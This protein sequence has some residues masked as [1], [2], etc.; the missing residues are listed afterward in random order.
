[1]DTVFR[2]RTI[3]WQRHSPLLSRFLETGRKVRD[4]KI[5][6]TQTHRQTD[7]QTDRQTHT[8]THTHTHRRRDRERQR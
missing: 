7:R 5:L 3:A 4:T 2:A 6:H 1:M 8:H